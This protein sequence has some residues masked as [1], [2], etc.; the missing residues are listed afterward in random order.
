MKASFSIDVS[1]SLDGETD[2]LRD[3]NNLDTGEKPVDNL[4][5]ESGSGSKK[6][7]GRYITVHERDKDMESALQHQAQLIGQYE[8]EEKAQREWEEKFR[9]SNSCEQV[10]FISF[11][12][13]VI[14]V[15][16]KKCNIPIPPWFGFIFEHTN[17][18]LCIKRTV[19]GGE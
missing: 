3:S 6:I 15:I 7:Y 1:N 11:H 19:L 17:L 12:Y 16:H 18:L 8:K 9:E 13:L 14:K 4:M 2:A 10:S 5:L